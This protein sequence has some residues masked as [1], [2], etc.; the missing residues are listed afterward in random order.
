MI[1]CGSFFPQKCLTACIIF[2]ALMPLHAQKIRV[3]CLQGKPPFVDVVAG[4]C[5]GL[6][7]NTFF[8]II[9]NS[10]IEY[11]MGFINSTTLSALSASRPICKT[12]TIEPPECVVSKSDI[13]SILFHT[14]RTEFDIAITFT[15]A[16]SDR[17]KFVD[18]SIPL[19]ETYY[20]VLVDRKY[21]P[22]SGA[23]LAE[24]VTRPIV[25]YLFSVITLFIFGISLIFLVAETFLVRHSSELRDIRSYSARLRVSLVAAMESVFTFSCPLDLHSPFSMLTVA[26][27]SY[28]MTFVLAVFTALITSQLTAKQANA[29]PPALESLAGARIGIQGVLLKAFL[30]GPRV[31]A[32]PVVYDVLDG[33]VAAFYAGDNPDALDGF[34]TQ[35]EIVNY[36]QV[37][38]AGSR[39][40]PLRAPSKSDPFFHGP[41]RLLP[42][43]ETNP[44][45]TVAESLR[46]D[47][48]AKLWRKCGRRHLLSTTACPPKL[49]IHEPPLPVPAPPACCR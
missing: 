11:S 5:V 37:R 1:C 41:A 26:V 18:A 9:Q 3:G 39:S 44:A 8:E 4:K 49:S 15:F 16:T 23:M 47:A 36:F 35:T 28:A 48:V 27:T 13:P 21:A 10:G 45:R 30:A 40:N 6:L 46:E 14:N 29:A 25:M 42:H 33:P 22:E 17:L 19:V 38:H 43:R 24:T 20:S 31:N 12:G 32:I 34:A 7:A 2:S